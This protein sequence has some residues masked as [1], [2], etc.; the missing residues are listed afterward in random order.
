[1]VIYNVKE[2]NIVQNGHKVTDSKNK[3]KTPQI[4]LLKK[5]FQF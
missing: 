4:L 1:M 5:K 2:Y 3:K